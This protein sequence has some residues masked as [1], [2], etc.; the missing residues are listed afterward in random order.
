MAT[1]FTKIITG[2]IPA[3]RVYQDDH[4]DAFLDINPARPGHTLVVPRQEVPY[5][6]DL[7]PGEY[8]ALWTAVREVA[9]RLKRATGCERVVVVAYGADVPHAHIHLIPLEAGGSLPFPQA[10]PAAAADLAAMAERIRMASRPEYDHK[11]A[12]LVVDVQNDLADPGGSLY[13]SGAEKMIPLINSEI[14]RAGEAGATIV[15]SRDW[16]PPTTPHFA[17]DGGTWPVHCVAETPGADFHPGLNVVPGSV[18]TLKGTGGE[19]AYSAFSMRQPVD[20][21]IT[22]TGL[23]DALRENHIARVVIVG[24]ATDYCIK[25]T[26][27][28]AVCLGFGAEV[29]TEATRPIELLP[30]DGAEALQ[31]MADQDV[32]IW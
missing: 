3:H 14:A 11:T 28:D 6:F 9:G 8:A 1:I 26:A 23:E 30:G 5:L 17:S 31:Q 20:G 19:D 27:L 2:E 12:L 4:S 7:E 32:E 13:V 29:L 24:L 16:H 15:Y 10:L 18:F 22:S 21:S 25:E